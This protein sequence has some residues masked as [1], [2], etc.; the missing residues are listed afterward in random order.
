[1]E[2]L[3]LPES[4][5]VKKTEDQEDSDMLNSPP[6]KDVKKPLKWT[7]KKLTEELLK[8]TLPPLE[9]P[10]EPEG[11]TEVEEEEEEAE[12]PVMEC[13]LTITPLEKET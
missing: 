4:L 2:L 7:D 9:D 10:V 8:S 3:I 5:K 11:V 12:E 6:L 13:L 1:M